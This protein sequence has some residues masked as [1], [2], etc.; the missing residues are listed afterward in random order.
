MASRTSLLG[1]LPSCS[2]A[3]IDEVRVHGGHE[4]VHTVASGWI[5]SSTNFLMAFW[6]C[7]CFYVDVRRYTGAIFSSD[8]RVIGA[9]IPIRQPCWLSIWNLAQLSGNAAVD[10]ALFTLD[11]TNLQTLVLRSLENFVSV[12]AVESFRGILSG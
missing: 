12:E 10:D 7:R 9:V 1:G 4:A 8:L 11:D 5:T 6:N 2:L 3:Y